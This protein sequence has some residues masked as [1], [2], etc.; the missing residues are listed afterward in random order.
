MERKTEL[1]TRMGG[2][3][4]C[5]AACPA[6]CHQ[7]EREIALKMGREPELQHEAERKTAERCLLRCLAGGNGMRRRI[8]RL[9]TLPCAA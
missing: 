9:L 5:E 8:E 2:K 6:L 1:L 3:R 4:F 7:M